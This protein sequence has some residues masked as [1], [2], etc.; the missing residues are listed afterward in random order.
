M[1]RGVSARHP[2]DR[3]KKSQKSRLNQKTTRGQEG[4]VSWLGVLEPLAIL[5]RFVVLQ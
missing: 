4:G 5:N 1:G 3:N 2:T